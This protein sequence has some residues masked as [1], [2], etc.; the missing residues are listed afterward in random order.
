MLT[1][2]LEFNSSAELI[3]ISI[4]LRLL[5]FQSGMKLIH[6][7]FLKDA[8]FVEKIS[9]EHLVV[10][11]EKLK[12]FY[13][14]NLSSCEQGCALLLCL[15]NIP[16]IALEIPVSVWSGLVSMEKSFVPLLQLKKFP[17]GL[18]MIELL[19]QQL[20]FSDLIALV[21]EMEEEQGYGIGL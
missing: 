2:T 12:Y 4:L 6:D 13:I 18:K 15:L 19:S 3:D 1:R 9:I 14:Q 10:S 21:E 16:R 20:E 7:I 11:D 5:S 8:T 17:S